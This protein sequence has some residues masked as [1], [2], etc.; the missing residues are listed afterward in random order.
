MNKTRLSVISTIVLTL[1]GIGLSV[2]YFGQKPPKAKAVPPPTPSV[3]TTKPQIINFSR[4]EIADTYEERSQGLQNRKELCDDC[5]MIFVFEKESNLSFWM[6]NTSLP[7]DMIFVNAQG[8]IV[9]IHENTV[10]FQLSPSYET[11]EPAMYV[12]E[13]NTGFCRANEIREGA[14]LDIQSLLQKGQS[15]DQSYLSN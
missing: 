15:F 9:T 14:Y 3:D 1:L 11:R 5:G 12:I 2:L 13:V 4:L 8:K 10:P 7:L 6:K